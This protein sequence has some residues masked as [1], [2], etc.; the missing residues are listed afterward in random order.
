MPN[1][2][3]SKMKIKTT[4]FPG[5]LRGWT[6]I[7]FAKCHCSVFRRY[8]DCWF[9][10]VLCKTGNKDASLFFPLRH[11]GFHPVINELSRRKCLLGEKGPIDFAKNVRIALGWEGSGYEVYLELWAPFKAW[12]H[13]RTKSLAPGVEEG[14]P[15]PQEWFQK[16]PSWH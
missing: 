7:S 5:L 15:I 11:S 13:G 12:L 4:C 3:K 16:Q 8:C 6:E 1:F 10:A 9:E 14:F 2:L